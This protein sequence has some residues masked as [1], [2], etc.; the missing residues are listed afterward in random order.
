MTDD[1]PDD[2]VRTAE[3]VKGAPDEL[4]PHGNHL[5]R[6]P[7]SG[8]EAM[9]INRSGFVEAMVQFEHCDGDGNRPQSCDGACWS[10]SAGVTWPRRESTTEAREQRRHDESIDR[11]RLIWREGRYARHEPLTYLNNFDGIR[12]ISMLV[13]G[14]A[15]RDVQ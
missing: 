15:T 10:C 5:H 7:L 8:R 12:M 9:E 11:L 4:S 2:R 14:I 13:D 3:D 1:P 6:A